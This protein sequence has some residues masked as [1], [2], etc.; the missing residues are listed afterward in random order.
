MSDQ[1]RHH[2]LTDGLTKLAAQA[3]VY[4]DSAQVAL[5]G[6]SRTEGRFAFGPL[7]RDHFW[8]KLPDELRHSARSLVVELLALSGQVVEAAHDAPLASAAD[9]RDVMLGAKAMRAALQLREFLSWETQVIHDEGTVLGTHPPGQSDEHACPPDQAQRAFREWIDKFRAIVDLA[10]ASRP[11]RSLGAGD[12]LTPAK[13]RPSTAF[14][15]MSMESELT[16]VADK[17]REVFGLFGI[18]A[19]RADDIEHE[20]VITKKILDEIQTSEFCFADLTGER[21]NVYYEIGYAHALGRPVIMYRKK[22]T[23]IHFD[24]AQYNCP[25]YSSLRE[26]KDKLTIRLEQITNRRPKSSG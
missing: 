26:L 10:M 1:S 11:T 4:F 16:D 25:E 18:K 7:E 5:E 14:I 24:L 6:V 15:I 21:P 22:G 8:E 13:Y 19:V 9:E 12:S 2:E 23:R 20:G 3:A 17:I